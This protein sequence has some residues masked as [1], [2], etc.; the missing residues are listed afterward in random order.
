MLYVYI[1][2]W[3]AIVLVSQKLCKKIL[4]DLDSLWSSLGVYGSLSLLGVGKAILIVLQIC[5][6]TTMMMC[7]DDLLEKGY[8]LGSATSLFI[9]TNAW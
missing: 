9:A 7:L 6:A 5:L 1:Y 4:G 2:M 3:H 8:G